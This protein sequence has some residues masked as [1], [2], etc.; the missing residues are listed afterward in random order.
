MN[1]FTMNWA[2]S[3]LQKLLY[4]LLIATL[5]VCN[6]TLFPVFG[7]DAKGQVLNMA[8][9]FFVLYIATMWFSKLF[10]TAGRRVQ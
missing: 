3:L 7:D 2:E 9:Q 1:P 6:I 8:L 5:V 10:I 4:F